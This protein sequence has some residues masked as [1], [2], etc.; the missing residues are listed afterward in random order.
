M[1]A[2]ARRR[3]KEADSRAQLHI[4]LS[5]RRSG[6]TEPHLAADQIPDIDWSPC[7]SFPEKYGPADERRSRTRYS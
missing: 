4:S 7:G 3:E 2:H 1:Q 6:V 5:E